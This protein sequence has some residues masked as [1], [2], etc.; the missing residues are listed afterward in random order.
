MPRENPNGSG[1]EHIALDTSAP[2]LLFCPTPRHSMVVTSVLRRRHCKAPVI[3][4]IYYAVTPSTAFFDLLGDDDVSAGVH[5]QRHGAAA[6]HLRE[7][8][9]FTSIY[10]LGDE[11]AVRCSLAVLGKRVLFEDEKEERYAE[12]RES[13]EQVRKEVALPCTSCSATPV[14]DRPQL[15]TIGPRPDTLFLTWLVA[16]TNSPLVYLPARA[17]W[18]RCA[19]TSSPPRP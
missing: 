5:A 6:E 15:D 18:T 1:V 2:T 16:L 3:S 7:V 8:S 9:Q 4:P 14:K 12:E 17:R 11:E 19:S 10:L 13:L